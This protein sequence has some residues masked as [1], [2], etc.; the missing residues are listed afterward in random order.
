[1]DLEEYAKRALKRGQKREDIENTLA[2]RIQEIRQSSRESALLLSKAVVDEANFTA[3]DEKKSGVTMGKFGVG[4]RGSGDFYIHEKIA[5]IIGNTSAIIGSDQLDDSGVVKAYDK[6]I[7]ITV[8]GMHSRL[9]DYPFLAGFHVTRASLRDI[10]V[11]GAEP[12]ALFSDIHL[13]D[14]GDV[15]KIFDYTAGISAVSEVTDVP[16]VT[17]STL[18]IGGDVVLGERLTGCVGAVG[19]VEKEGLTPRINARVGDRILMSEGSGG[20]TIVATALYNGKHEIVTET[21][22]VKFLKACDVLIKTGLVKKVHAMTDVTNGGIRGDAEEISKTAG[23]KLVFEENKI[24]PLVNP[25]VLKML[26]DLHIDYLGVSIDALLIIVSPSMAHEVKQ[27]LH[28]VIK[29]D[30]IGWVEKGQG[31]ELIV[32][33]RRSEIMPKF[34]ESAYTPVKMVIGDYVAANEIEA[35]RAQIDIAAQNSITK[36]KKMV[37]YLINYGSVPESLF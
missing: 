11:M 16:L 23:V 18:R 28:G 8:D 2:D 1:M 33:G 4:S 6:Y 14:D 24:R 15:S 37:N 26:D 10:F 36:K 5:D 31:A 9:S 12:I 35:M 27:A 7:V 22:N 30:E 19:I 20:G 34:R 17:G 29:V 3:R 25:K 13:A 32:N 21:L